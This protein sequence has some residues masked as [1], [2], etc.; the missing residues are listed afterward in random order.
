MF[1]LSREPSRTASPRYGADA[2][3]GELAHK[4]APDGPV[5]DHKRVSGRPTEPA[6]RPGDLVPDAFVDVRRSRQ[7]PGDL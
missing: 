1:D 4:V 5:V 6:A 7:L 2:R 3:T